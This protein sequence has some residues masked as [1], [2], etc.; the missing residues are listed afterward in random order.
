MVAVTAATF[1]WAVAEKPFAEYMPCGD[2]HVV[3]PL[4]N[5][6]LIM[7][8]D[9]LGHGE[10]AALAARVAVEAVSSQ[11]AAKVP[12]RQLVQRCHSAL[13]GSSRGVVLSVAIYNA[14]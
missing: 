4:P 1:E 8:V 14:K 3:V 11:T 10:Q 7:V 6:A 2:H 12:L 13:R 9:G 5:G